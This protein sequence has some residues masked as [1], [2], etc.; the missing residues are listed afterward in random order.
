LTSFTA[1][2]AGS[3]LLLLAA[4]AY[5]EAGPIPLAVILLFIATVDHGIQLNG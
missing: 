4:F 2:T 3:L 1:R 5:G